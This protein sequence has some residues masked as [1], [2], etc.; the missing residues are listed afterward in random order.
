MLILPTKKKNLKKKTRSLGTVQKPPGVR[1]NYFNAL[2]SL[3]NMLNIAVEPINA[4]LN[5]DRSPQA[6]ATLIQTQFENTARR[7]DETKLANEFAKQSSSVNKKSL[8]SIYRQAFSVNS[9]RIIDEPNIQDF[10][11]LATTENISLIR[12]IHS[13]YWGKVTQAITANFRGEPQVDNVSLNERLKKIGNISDNRA[14]IIARDQTKKLSTALTR[15]RHQNVGVKKYIWHNVGDQRVVGN[16]AG[17]Y[18]KGRAIHL[19][20]WS[21]EGKTFYY[22]RPPADGHPGTPILCRCY[23]EPVIDIDDA[24]IIYSD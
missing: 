2:Q 13:D 19:N 14:N 24:N 17:L 11:A 12:S 3:V 6:I 8:E 23:E 21:R 20:H 16:P 5:A 22:D 7:L 9:A 15:L 18:P 1:K 4:V 10:L